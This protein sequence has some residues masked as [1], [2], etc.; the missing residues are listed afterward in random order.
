MA[1]KKGKRTI[2][3][4]ND[5]DNRLIQLVDE[6]LKHIDIGIYESHRTIERQ[7][8]LFK[9][10]LSQIDGIT[11]KGKHNYYPSLAIDCFPY[12]KGHDSF[13]GSDKSELMF[14]RMYWHFYR[15]SLKL[16]IPI[17]WGGL[18]SFRDMP[19]IQLK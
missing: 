19:H 7:N 18:W 17:Q 5:A 15:A 16:N 11:Q 4:L 6:V 8:K 12:I 2:R 14:Y 9:K 10:G 13:D 1:Y 3:K